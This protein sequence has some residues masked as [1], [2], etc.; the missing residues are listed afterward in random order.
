MEV[1][2]GNAAIRTTGNIIMNANTAT[3]ALLEDSN[4]LLFNTNL[5]FYDGTVQSTAVN[6]VDLSANIGMIINDIQA[7]DANIGAQPF[8]MANYQNWTSNVTSVSAALNQLAERI[9]SLG[10]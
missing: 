10:A 2:G 9:K 4:F 7:I 3:I 5:Q 6:A 1:V 8:T